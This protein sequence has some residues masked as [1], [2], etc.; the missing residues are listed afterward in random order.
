MVQDDR[1]GPRG[2]C[3]QI[4]DNIKIA[5]ALGTLYAHDYLALLRP[6]ALNH[7]LTTP[8]PP[9]LASETVNRTTS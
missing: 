2:A 6:A 9:L 8:S 5:P 7:S 1:E 3:R 4:K